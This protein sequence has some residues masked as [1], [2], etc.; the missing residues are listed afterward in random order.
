M[1]NR[2]HLMTM[3]SIWALLS[4]T[5]CIRET[6]ES[7]HSFR[8]DPGPI[9]PVITTQDN[10]IR[11]QRTLQLNMNGIPEDHLHHIQVDDT[12]TLT[13]DQDTTTSV[14]IP[15]VC[16]LADLN[17]CMPSV[18]IDGA[19]ADTTLRAGRTTSSHPDWKQCQEWMEEGTYIQETLQEY[20]DLSDIP[21]TVYTFTDPWGEPADKDIPNPTIRVMFEMDYKKTS[22]ISYGFNAGL[23]NA[24]EGIMGRGFSIPDIDRT[25]TLIVIGDDI[26]NMTIQGYATGG[27]DNEETIDAG[28][29]AKRY[30]SNL[31]TALHT[32]AHSWYQEIQEDETWFDLYFSLLKDMIQ[33]VENQPL[34]D[35]EISHVKRIFLL[36]TSI[37]IPEDTPVTLHVSYQKETA[38]DFAGISGTDPDLRGIRILNL[39]S[40]VAQTQRLKLIHSD[41]ISIL[42]HNT[43]PD[44]SS[45]SDHFYLDI[46]KS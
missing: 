25:Y 39:K 21:V 2:R 5:G 38:Y 23:N 12:Y 22:V 33:D 15:F 18:E 1:S 36:E 46:K 13:S 29:T 35:M 16:D 37:T 17:A 42:R 11:T 31:E 40:A 6:E 4:C 27:W 10:P 43:D 32:A 8:Y 45:A 26:R 30:S 24:E 19:A 3:C 44:L 7:E 41:D 9:L 14:L 34:E 28:V 20:P